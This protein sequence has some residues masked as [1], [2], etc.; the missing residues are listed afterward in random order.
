MMSQAGTAMR[1][2]SIVILIAA[3]CTP[4]LARAQV[5]LQSRSTSEG[6]GANKSL[7]QTFDL[8]SEIASY[9]MTYDI[10]TPEGT[11]PG[12]CT[13]HFEVFR[14]KLVP[15]A[16]TA[17]GVANWYRQG[18][19]TV[20][21]DG[22]SIYDDVARFRTI[23]DG[24]ADALLEGTWLTSKGPLRVR[25]AVRR[26][27]DKLLMQAELGGETKIRR[28]E[29][30]LLCYPQG[31]EKP[32]DRHMATI[33]RDVASAP[34]LTL[35]PAREP[36]LMYYD[37]G[38]AGRTRG[39]PCG[40]VYAPQEVASVSVNLGPY[41][42]YTTLTAK[43]GERK[44]T[45]GL[46]DFTG[47]GDVATM[48]RHLTHDTAT[49]AADLQAVAHADW[50]QAIPAVRLGKAYAG[51]LA[52]RVQDRNR[53]TAYDEMTS[54]VVTPHVPWAKPLSGGPLRVLVV[55]PRWQQRETVEL[56][57]R[58]DMQYDTF[59]FAEPDALTSPD[60]YLYGSYELYGYPRKTA[61]TVLS[62]LQRKL[63]PRRD[64]LI[65]SGFLSTLIPENLRQTI[66]D[67]VGGGTG[68]VLLGRPRDLL[69]PL[70]KQL[71]PARWKPDVAAIDRLPV[72]GKMTAAK[73][74]I[75]SAYTL[76][77]GR[78]LALNYATGANLLTP[79]PGLDDP[80][81]RDYY[82]DYQRLA[83]AAVL[84]V[85][86]R[87]VPP[88]MRQPLPLQR[89][90]GSQIVAVEV[91]E[92]SLPRGGTVS[93]VVRLRE[94]PS[95]ARLDLELWDA[96]GRLVRRQEI[97]PAGVEI[98]FQFPLGHGPAIL[99]E[100]RAR[101]SVGA[102]ELDTRS[103][104]L[105]VSD[106]SVDDF[107]FLAWANGGNSVLSHNILD[108]LAE[109]GVD[110]IDNT[111]IGGA[112]E[113]QAATMVRNAAG[114]GLR[115]IPYIT[116][117]SSEQTSG[118]VR[119]PCLSDP[120]WQGKWTAGLRDRARGAAPYGPPGYTLGD[121]NFLVNRPLDVCTA[122]FCLA[123]FRQWL[124]KQ[125]GS[126]QALNASWRTS[127]GDWDE[128]LPATLD[129]V[130][131]AP[132]FWP[133]WADHRLFM[134]GVFTAAHALGRRAIRESDPQARVGF[135]GI[136]SLDSWHGYDFYQLCR[137]CDMVE[138]YA[139]NGIMQMEYLRSWRQPGAVC[140]AWYNELGNRDETWVK[141]LGWH[142][143]FHGFNSSWYWTSYQTGPALLFPDL[144]PTPQ[145][146][147]M[148]QSHAEI[149]GGIGKLLLHARR[150]HDGV[151]IH[152]SQASVHA[153][154]LIGRS[155]VPPQTG[156]ARW[157]EDL[158]LQYNMLASEEIN[159]GQLAGYK[160]LLL[161]SSAAIGEAEA[162]AITRFVEQGGLVLADATPGIL[163]GH[164]RLREQGGLDRLFGVARSGLP[165]RGTVDCIELKHEQLAGRLPMVVCDRNLRAAG[166]EVWA[167]AETTPAVLVHRVGRGRAVLLNAAVD[168]YD[169][170]RK[171]GQTQ[172]MR[173]L[174][175]QL[176]ESVGVAAKVH[177]LVDG[178]DAPACETVRFVDGG[179][180]YVGIIQ[181]QDCA[182]AKQARDVT[183]L[184][185]M[186]AEVYDVRAK[187]S[188]GR[189]R[190]CSTRLQPGD[191]KL[192]ALLPYAVRELTLGAPQAAV[193]LGS[194]FKLRVTL[195]V[196]QERLAG[197]HCLRVEAIDPQGKTVRPYAQ[198]VLTDRAATDVGIELALNDPAGAWQFRVTD[199]ATG[200]SALAR[201]DVRS[202]PGIAE[203]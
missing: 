146:R 14:G 172:L 122:P 189:G 64:C 151:A 39:G 57:Q 169:G 63:E 154:T 166:A 104:A 102:A 59:S 165:V 94:V 89:G 16:M 100:V 170:M 91:S 5:V 105:S 103:A 149:M 48:R 35:D 196:G 26:G 195:G 141:R 82:E 200:R 171:M 174:G 120:L 106:R 53:S 41:S 18:F 62:E 12:K 203:R 144:R 92:K 7:I 72:L 80:D 145:L 68:L 37:P 49:I 31:F 97:R 150:L 155:P 184:L 67:K 114:H 124:A 116:R 193:A 187:Q 168:Q 199:V 96:L 201:V 77:K 191:A 3:F 73:Q 128:A 4:G 147:W 8:G 107:H 45:L 130:R 79:S 125:Y 162:Q 78:V 161:P 85:T 95:Q 20:R 180:Q 52:G 46:W 127:Y 99:Y 194:E 1:R 24:G 44:I 55:G 34:R 6:T 54:Q 123:G 47:I 135:D 153:G 185:P 181:D 93:G 137:A 192:L 87:E 83:I 115:S 110:W 182:D 177:I 112:T 60:L 140:G 56:A 190:T 98:P 117:I 159:E 86:G 30:A 84:W 40:L 27:D 17:P 173:Q 136:F 2:L 11:P 121:E 69:Q 33:V 139:V 156:M 197:P 113:E 152:Y 129:E 188:L 134:D 198:N 138:V 32:Y 81:V 118:R 19:F 167:A 183:I 88:R 9:G 74:P 179:I 163:D 160:V 119:Q 21:V 43:P 157:I 25:F 28:L 142:L 58:L 148:E 51:F 23:R 22:E 70:G 13:S 186:E 164:C 15:L 75:W 42:V 132:A 131:A 158:G 61:A 178:A 36:W 10:S 101:L 109:H 126:L 90:R 50:E 108:V 65:L 38:M 66:F 76:G 133:R 29:L 143:L 71:S 202:G 111:G 175:Q 176:L